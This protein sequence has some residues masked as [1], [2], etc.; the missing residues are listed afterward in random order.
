MQNVWSTEGGIFFVL[1]YQ[2][3]VIVTVEKMKFVVQL[4]DI[5]IRILQH[6]NQPLR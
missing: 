1:S 2:I 4:D 6:D 3:H 5:Q